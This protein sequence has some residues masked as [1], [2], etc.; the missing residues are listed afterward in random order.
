MPK[1]GKPV[2]LKRVTTYPIRKRISKVDQSLLARLPS[3]DQPLTDFFRTWPKLLKAKEFLRIAE[4]IAHAHRTDRA[5]IWMMGAHPIK[6]GLSPLIVDLIKRKVI[7]CV[8]MNGAAAIHD[9]ELAFF[10]HTSEDVERGL[11]DG[12][13]GMA[14]ETGEGMNTIINEGVRRGYGIGEALGQSIMRQDAKFQE[15]SILC[16]GFKDNLPVTVHIA[17][18]TDIIHQHPS[19]DGVALGKGGILDFRILAGQ[20]A[21]LNDGGVVINCGS[22]VMMPEVFL[23]A[24]TI[25]RN[26]GSTIK[27]FTAVNL[28]MFEHYRPRVNV[29]TRPTKLGGEAYSIVGHHEIMLPLLYAA[30]LTQL[31]S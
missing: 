31:K 25:A 9:F 19:V 29:L 4:R 11:A 26:L 7:S 22:A 2:D 5:V 8:A 17:L 6:C 1:K 13:F 3:P 21:G 28:D 16:Q 27:N 15:L 18:G 23:K 20:L 10:G 12:S 24:L 14:R 30:L